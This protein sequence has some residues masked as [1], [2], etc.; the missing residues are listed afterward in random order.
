M[1]CKSAGARCLVTGDAD[2]W[3]WSILPPKSDCD[4]PNFG[5]AES[6]EQ[7]EKGACNYVLHAFGKTAKLAK[8]TDRSRFRDVELCTPDPV[9][10]HG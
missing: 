3:L 9:A 1:R 8:G 6:S 2:L 10:S 4:L 7:A 5:H